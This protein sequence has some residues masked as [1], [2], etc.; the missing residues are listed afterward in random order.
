MT[1]TQFLLGP[2]DIHCRTWPTTRRPST[3]TWRTP[4]ATRGRRHQP[5]RMLVDSLVAQLQ[6]VT[7]DDPVASDP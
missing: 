7:Y 5:P 2:L 4:P 6:R 3:A 1:V